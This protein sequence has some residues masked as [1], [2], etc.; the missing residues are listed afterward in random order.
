M[1]GEMCEVRR[2][3][4]ELPAKTIFSLGTGTLLEGWGGIPW[5]GDL[6]PGGRAD[7]CAAEL[8]ANAAD[9]LEDFLRMEAP[10]VLTMAGGRV[11]RRDP[12][13]RSGV[14]QSDSPA[15]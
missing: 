15:P 11:L 1:A 5:T 3:F 4:P 14:G 10:S 8:P 9:P 13:R 2:L 6:R 12:L 7:L